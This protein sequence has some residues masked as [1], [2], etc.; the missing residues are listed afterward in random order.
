[1]AARVK[2]RKKLLFVPIPGTS[3][4][5][6]QKVEEPA[7]PPAPAPAAGATPGKQ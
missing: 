1:V 5:M 7:A 3:R 2:H 6:T 4:K